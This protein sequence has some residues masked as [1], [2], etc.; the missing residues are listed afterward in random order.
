MALFNFFARHDF[1]SAEDRKEIM[2][3]IQSAE[4]HTSG[5]IRIFIE[6]K[7]KW[8]STIRRAEEVFLDLKMQETTYRNAVLIYVAYRDREFAV[9][10]DQGCF[11]KFP[12]DF[13]KLTA[14][15]LSVDF[16]AD[17]KTEGLIQ[18]IQTIGKELANF[19]P[20]DNNIKKNELPDEIVFGK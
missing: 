6:Q 3:A 18:C 1:L 7:N 10:G 16:I 8:V 2:H 20:C 9:Y 11:Q 12:E 15:Y 14:R 5:E 4:E 19:Y 17:K 13:W